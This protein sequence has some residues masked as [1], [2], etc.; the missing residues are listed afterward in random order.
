[1]KAKKCDIEVLQ[2]E[3]IP[4]A[5]N[6]YLHGCHFLQILGGT[7]VGKTYFADFLQSHLR[8]FWILEWQNPTLSP[9]EFQT[10]ERQ[11]H[12]QSFATALVGEAAILSQLRG[13]NFNRYTLDTRFHPA[14]LGALPRCDRPILFYYPQT[15]QVSPILIDFSL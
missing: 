14:I 6:Q 10:I 1:M 9:R 3:E 15:P 4:L 8:G 13:K 5:L 7:G 12:G 11:L 2:K